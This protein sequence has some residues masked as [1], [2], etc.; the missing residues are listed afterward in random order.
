M[1]LSYFHLQ[2]ET[3][4][5]KDT[6]NEINQSKDNDRE[7]SSAA[8]HATEQKQSSAKRREES[9]FIDSGINVHYVQIGQG[10]PLMCSPVLC[11]QIEAIAL[12]S[13]CGRMGACISNPM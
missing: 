4:L 12:I 2:E 3:A 5:L 1:S 8:M 10:W 7:M 6:E 13:T 11:Q 9:F